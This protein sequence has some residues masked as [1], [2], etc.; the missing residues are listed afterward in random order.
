MGGTNN[1]I[2][3]SCRRVTIEGT[4]FITQR[5]LSEGSKFSETP[6]IKLVMIPTILAVK[7][8]DP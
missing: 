6:M 7:Y 4:M 2:S 1:L 5:A 3:I 8:K